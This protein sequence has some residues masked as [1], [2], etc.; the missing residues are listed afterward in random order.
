MQRAKV[1]VCVSAAGCRH[2]GSS[3][4]RPGKACVDGANA[5]AGVKLHWDA[6]MLLAPSDTDGQHRPGRTEKELAS[7]SWRAGRGPAACRLHYCAAPPLLRNLTIFRSPSSRAGTLPKGLT[8]VGPADRAAWQGGAP[9]SVRG[10]AA[11][12]GRKLPP[13]GTRTGFPLC[14]TFKNHSDLCSRFSRISRLMTSTSSPLPS[15]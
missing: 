15:S 12:L 2:Q 3:P 6:A 1:P 10:A 13:L 5:V 7:P 8:C 14:H 9:N 11:G 4:D